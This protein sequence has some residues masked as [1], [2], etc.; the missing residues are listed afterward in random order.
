VLEGQELEGPFDAVMEGVGGPSLERSVQALAQHGV[1]V[2][3]G[4]VAGQP[5]RLGLADFARHLGGRVQAFFI[6]GTDVRTFGKDLG[7]LARLVAE[8]RLRPQVGL[9][10]SWRDLA[11]GIAALRERRVNGK[12]VLRID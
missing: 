7:F 5:A 2:L 1:A 10:V 8:G 3:Y 12:V 4:A 11:T 9:E 6:Y